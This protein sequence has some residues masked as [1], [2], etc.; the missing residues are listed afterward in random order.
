MNEQEKLIY[1]AGKIVGE[2]KGLTKGLIIGSVCIA[3]VLLMMILK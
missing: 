1:E 3:I 2:R